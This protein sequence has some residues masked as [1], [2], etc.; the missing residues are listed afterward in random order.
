MSFTPWSKEHLQRPR[1]RG[2]R[3]GLSRPGEWELRRKELEDRFA[4]VD[5]PLDHPDRRAL[6]PELAVANTGYGDTADAWVNTGGLVSR[7]NFATR[8]A[9]GTMPGV[10]LP[11]AVPASNELALHLG[12]PEFQRH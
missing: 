1:A 6:W 11:R 8:L 5:G 10:T 4:A 9:S 12:S 3:Q 2:V 7:M